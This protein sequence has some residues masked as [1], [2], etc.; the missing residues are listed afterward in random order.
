M[1]TKII[2]NNLFDC[3]QNMAFIILA[4][5]LIITAVILSITKWLFLT[6]IPINDQKKTNDCCT[7]GK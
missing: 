4:T 7:K 2:L 1:I 3:R 5:F 6:E